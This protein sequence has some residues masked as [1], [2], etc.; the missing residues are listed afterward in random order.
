MAWEVNQGL[1]INLEGWDGEGDG[2]EV[3][4]WGD[5][6]ILVADSCRSLT[7]NRNILQRN[8]PSIK[9]NFKRVLLGKCYRNA[10]GIFHCAV[11]DETPVWNRQ[12]GSVG[13]RSSEAGMG[14]GSWARSCKTGRHQGCGSQALGQDSVQHSG[15]ECAGWESV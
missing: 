13:S 15:R 14:G 9:N 11:N 12:H 1:C 5:I 4:K 3:Q 7:E 6:C 2:R 10:V 8:Y